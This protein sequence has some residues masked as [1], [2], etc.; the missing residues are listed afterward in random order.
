MCIDLLQ[1]SG[2]AFERWGNYKKKMEKPIKEIKFQISLP[3]V[4][5]PSFEE[6]FQDSKLVNPCFIIPL[7]ESKK[8]KDL[9]QVVEYKDVGVSKGVEQRFVLVNEVAEKAER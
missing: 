1:M 8:D 5:P 3:K 6:S 9:I 2:Y 4:I 7:D